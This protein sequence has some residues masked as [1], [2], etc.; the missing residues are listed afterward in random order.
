MYPAINWP[1]FFTEFVIALGLDKLKMSFKL[2]NSRSSSS[3]QMFRCAQEDLNSS[4]FGSSAWAM[5]PMQLGSPANHLYNLG[6]MTT[7]YD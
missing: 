5:N 4:S 1:M 3:D 7:K 2:A 6:Y